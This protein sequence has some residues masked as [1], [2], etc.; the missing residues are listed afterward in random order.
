MGLFWEDLLPRLSAV[1]LASRPPASARTS[2][3]GPSTRPNRFAAIERVG[4]SLTA[5]RPA[6]N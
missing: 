3:A 6:A 2:S 5:S 4:E 1:E